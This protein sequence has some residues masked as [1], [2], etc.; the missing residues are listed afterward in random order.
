M[1][2]LKTFENFK[3]TEI[4]EEIDWKDLATK[5]GLIKDP[6]KK[7]ET[8]IDAIKK[9]PS[10]KRTYEEWLEKDP[11]IAEKYVEFWMNNPGVKYCKWDDVKKKFIDTGIYRDSSGILGTRSL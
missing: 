2:H 5:I 6:V 10:K 7:R 11:E 1:Q 9:H 4:N 8:T 3:N